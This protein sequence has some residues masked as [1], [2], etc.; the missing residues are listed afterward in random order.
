MRTPSG[1]EWIIN[2]SGEIK[3]SLEDNKEYTIV[4][5][6]NFSGKSQSSNSKYGN[7]AFIS[8]LVRGQ[9]AGGFVVVAVPGG[10]VMKPSD[11]GKLTDKTNHDEDRLF[12]TRKRLLSC[13]ARY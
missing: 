6:K 4:L 5:N 1:R 2:D 11:D 13:K 3:S 12:K 9:L 10:T 8:G 7:V